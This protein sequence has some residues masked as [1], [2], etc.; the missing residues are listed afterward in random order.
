LTGEELL[1]LV[2]DMLGSLSERIADDLRFSIAAVYPRVRASV[3]IEISGHGRDQSM[4]IVKHLPPHEKTPVHVAHTKADEI[5][6][7]VV[8]EHEEM[9]ADG[10][11]IAPPNAV[12]T[13]LNLPIPRKRAVQTPGGRQLI[14]MDPT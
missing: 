13:D 4:L 8:A 2:Q 3:T 1:K 11:S 7:V 5:C 12:R 14:D 9:A 10:T 6:F